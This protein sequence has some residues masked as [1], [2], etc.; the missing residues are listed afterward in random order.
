MRCRVSIRNEAGEW[1]A[2]WEEHPSVAGRGSSRDA[3]LDRLR[4]A[5]LF[6]LEMCPCDVT[7]A[8]GLVLD[9]VEAR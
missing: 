5:I 9:V 1:L 4:A 3:A 7:T 2:R 8:D 6:D